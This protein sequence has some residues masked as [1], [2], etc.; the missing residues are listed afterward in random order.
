MTIIVRKILFWFFTSLLRT[1]NIKSGHILAGKLFVFL[2]GLS[3]SNF[4][5][6][7]KFGKVVIKQDK[8][9]PFYQ[10]CCSWSYKN[11]QNC[12]KGLGVTKIV[13]IFKFEG[14]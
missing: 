13:K 9:S 1:I 4:D 11:C 12:V 2:D 8:F 5:L 10:L 3:I 7:E 6:N 14:S